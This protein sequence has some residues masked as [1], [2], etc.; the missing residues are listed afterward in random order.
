MCVRRRGMARQL[1]PFITSACA[2][3]CFLITA[4][5]WVRDHRF[6][7]V[8]CKDTFLVHVGPMRPLLSSYPL[9]R[10]ARNHLHCWSRQSTFCDPV[11]AGLTTPSKNLP[12]RFHPLVIESLL[13]GPI[14]VVQ[15]FLLLIIEVVILTRRCNRDLFSSSIAVTVCKDW[16]VIHHGVV[17]CWQMYRH[18]A[19]VILQ[20]WGGEDGN[21]RVRS[22]L[23]FL[24]RYCGCQMDTARTGRQNAWQ[25]RNV[26]RDEEQAFIG[27]RSLIWVMVR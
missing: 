16:S 18:Q 15:R 9:A 8:A 25:V 2:L 19:R 4:V 20:D 14:S 7:F 23:N 17:D 10:E 6:C 27:R 11:D 13:C 22:A 5:L 1:R 3:L 26:Y 21:W 24:L 12:A